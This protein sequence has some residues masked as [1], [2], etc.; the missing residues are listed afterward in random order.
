MTNT[1]VASRLVEATSSMQTRN[2]FT[3]I[4]IHFT[5][6]PIEA[7]GA[8]AKEPIMLEKKKISED[9]KISKFTVF[10][11]CSTYFYSDAGMQWLSGIPRYFSKLI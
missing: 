10:A 2:R 1:L 9:G 8:V 11:K 7:N 6:C 5:E 4:Y 3:L